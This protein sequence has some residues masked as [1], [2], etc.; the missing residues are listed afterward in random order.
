MRHTSCADGIASQRAWVGCYRPS[1]RAS[2]NDATTPTAQAHDCVGRL[3]APSDSDSGSSSDSGR[4]IG[5]RR[6]APKV[7]VIVNLVC[8][9]FTRLTVMTIT[10]PGIRQ[11]LVWPRVR[12]QLDSCGDERQDD[13]HSKLACA[14][15]MSKSDVHVPPPSKRGGSCCPSAVV[16]CCRLRTRSILHTGRHVS[17]ATRSRSVGTPKGELRSQPSSTRGGSAP[18]C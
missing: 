5:A 15:Q 16:S 14:R 13:W 3:A 2:H 6:S 7:V 18:P 8:G 12:G 10:S 9:G 1:Q 17:S 11:R 4:C